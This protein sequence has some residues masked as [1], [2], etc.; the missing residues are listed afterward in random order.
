MAIGSVGIR[1][2]H[3]TNIRNG[4]SQAVKT[5]HSGDRSLGSF[6]ALMAAEPGSAVSYLKNLSALL[7]KSGVQLNP[8]SQQA[9]TLASSAKPAQL[10]QV[11]GQAHVLDGITQLFDGRATVL[12]AAPNATQAAWSQPSAAAPAG[13]Q[14]QVSA[15][16]PPVPGQAAPVAAAA[17]VVPTVPFVRASSVLRGDLAVTTLPTGQREFT[18]TTPGG[19]Q[20][21]VTQGQ[22]SLGNLPVSWA[23]G[24]IERQ[25]PVQFRGDFSDN[26]NF[27]HATGFTPDLPGF[28]T[29][30]FARSTG[31]TTLQL[32]DGRTVTPTHPAFLQ[33]TNKLNQW[34][35]LLPGEP[36]WVNN[37]WV[38]DE[39]PASYW[40][41]GRPVGSGSNRAVAAYNTFDGTVTGPAQELVHLNHGQRNWMAGVFS[42]PNPQTNKFTTYDATVIT[43][44]TDQWAIPPPSTQPTT[45]LKSAH[46]ATEVY[47]DE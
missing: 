25:V 45:P 12:N 27:F 6:Q 4:L 22:S 28:E 40:T 1:P 18:V 20:V 30:T 2:F 37:A 13:W 19:R 5:F 9:L 24:L 29:S 3:P 43:G 15:A 38:Y 16:V 35:V 21:K 47:G 14:P 39:N 33:V 34:G 23:Q 8:T 26:G 44:P 31:P 10:N 36:K 41:L 42:N 7:G 32:A 11:L 46:F 17:P